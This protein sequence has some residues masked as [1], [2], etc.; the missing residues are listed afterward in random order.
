MFPKEP[1]H[2]AAA[3]QHIPAYA[4][5]SIFSQCCPKDVNDSHASVTLG[6]RKKRLEVTNYKQKQ[7]AIRDAKYFFNLL[8]I[9]L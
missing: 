8:D 6:F 7:R 2:R 3:I 1:S 5:N 4:G 9:C